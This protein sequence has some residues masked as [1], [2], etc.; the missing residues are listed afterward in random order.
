MLAV[1]LVGF[2][3]GCVAE[4]SAVLVSPAQG[5]GVDILTTNDATAGVSNV[6]KFPTKSRFEI[7]S[8]LVVFPCFL[9]VRTR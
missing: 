1:P 2:W 7:C 3:V 8:R 5:L 9:S 6:P 4:A